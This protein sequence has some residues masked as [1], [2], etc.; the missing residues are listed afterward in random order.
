MT[1]ASRS[2]CLLVASL[3]ALPGCEARAEREPPRSAPAQLERERV[4]QY[5]MRLHF[6]DLRT[7]QHHLVDGRLK[8]AKAL[9][10]LIAN[11]EKDRGLL[12]WADESRE[13]VAAATALANASSVD[14]ALRQEVKIAIACANCHD[15][16]APKFLFPMP[17]RPPLADHTSSTVRMTRHRWATDRLWEGLV[18]SSEDHWRAGLAV[19]SETPLPYSRAREAPAFA[20]ALQ[21]RAN[22]ALREAP[23]DTIEERG[24]VYGQL[25]VTCAGCHAAVKRAK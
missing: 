1:S 8:E 6:D 11:P 19:I 23:S 18:A 13:L 4:V 20:S 3:A 12:P 2:T 17:G 22:Q 21:K 10:F 15:D 16:A 5:H 24:A 25:L 7:I 14:E 9:A